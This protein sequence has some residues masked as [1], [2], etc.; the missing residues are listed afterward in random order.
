MPAVAGT[1]IGTNIAIRPGSHI[2]SP[3]GPWITAPTTRCA[4]HRSASLAP[5]GAAPLD[6]YS[7]SSACADL[8]C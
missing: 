3:V 5:L 4:S 6:L 7:A 1:F 8:T 2:F